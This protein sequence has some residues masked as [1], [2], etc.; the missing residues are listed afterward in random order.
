MLAPMAKKGVSH[1]ICK[2]F[3]IGVGGRRCEVSANSHVERQLA[4]PSKPTCLSITLATA[5]LC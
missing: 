4:E 3:G 5:G 1:M 2:P